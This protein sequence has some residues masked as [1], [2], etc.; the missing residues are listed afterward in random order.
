MAEQNPTVTERIKARL[1]DTDAGVG[2]FM[3]G[4]GGMAAI[5]V[6]AI[7]GLYIVLNLLW[8]LFT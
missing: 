8:S 3:A 1:A 2:D 5:I 7:I 6:V 4:K